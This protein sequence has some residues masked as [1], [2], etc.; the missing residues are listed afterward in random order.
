MLHHGGCC[1]QT[2]DAWQHVFTMKERSVGKT[3]S[4]IRKTHTLITAE[5]KVFAQQAKVLKVS[6][7]LLRA[8]GAAQPGGGRF[9]GL[10]PCH[11]A[12]F[13]M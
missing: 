3:H 7:L 13:S 11:Q 12:G 9:N 8:A 1:D 4:L 5:N 2:G 6:T 10:Q